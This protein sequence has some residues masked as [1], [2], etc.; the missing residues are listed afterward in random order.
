MTDSDAASSAEVLLE[1][2]RVAIVGKLAGMSKREAQQLLRQHGAAVVE[3]PDSATTLVIV[4]EQDAAGS[5]TDPAA[6]V[7]AGLGA[8]ARAAYDSGQLTLLGESQLWQQLGLVDRQHEARGLYTVPML[9]GLLKESV[10]TIRRWQRL[11]WLVPTREVRRLA[12]FDFEEVA[13]ARR[14]Q[15]LLAAGMSSAAITKALATLARQLPDVRRPLA[16]LSIV[17]QGKQLLVRQEGGLVEPSGQ[18]RFDFDAPLESD[19]GESDSHESI[20][21]ESRSRQGGD[22][23]ILTFTPRGETASSETPASAFELQEA[24]SE[25]EAQGDL[26][27]AAEMYRAALAAGGPSAEICFL[28]AEVLY[29]LHDLPAARERY[30]M[31]VELNDD[32]VEARANLG[33]VL[34]E[35]GEHELAVSA[36][37][38]ALAFHDDYEDAHYH[39]GRTLDALGRTDEAASHWEA[40]LRLAPSSPWAD[41]ARER[42]NQ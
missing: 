4:G 22:R 17:I 13:T 35:L 10:P 31:A 6:A 18:L 20:S 24:A 38:G 21:G 40:F 42:L 28:L 7:I 14:V 15:E 39:L 23:A 25:L 1:G 32:Y 30:Y 29:Q 16:E 33:C 11:C 34:A 27:A 26:A 36:F 9:A 37:Q 2:Q 12:Y 41:E 5:L 8:G 19:T 3:H